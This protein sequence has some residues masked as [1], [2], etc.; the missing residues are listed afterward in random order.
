[1]VMGKVFTV[2][3][4][5]RIV[6]KLINGN[7]EFANLQVQ[8]EVSNFKKYPSGHCYFSLKDK[9]DTLKAVMFAGAAARLR[10]LPQNGNLILAL[11]RL[12]VFPRDG[13]YQLYVDMLMPLGAGNLM[14]AYEELKN[15]LQAEGLFEQ[16]RK[17]ALPEHPATVGIITSSAGAAVRDIITVSRRRDKGIKLLLYPVRVQGAEAAGELVYAIRFMNKHKLAEVLIVG[18]GGGSIE[19]LW[20]FNEEKVVRAI[21]ASELPIVSAVGHETD[22]TLADFAADVRAATPSAAAEIVVPDCNTMLVDVEKLGRRNIRAMEQF[23]SSWQNKLNGLERAWPFT[24]PERLFA[25]Q[26]V[27]LDKAAAG[28]QQV[29][30]TYLAKHDNALNVLESKLTALSPMAILARGYTVTETV[31]GL[32]V[33]SALQVKPGE[34]ILTRFQDGSVLSEIEPAGKA[35]K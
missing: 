9:N 4:V 20:A 13:V 6:K 10:Q 2:S 32:L 31:N 15:R 12:D 35:E 18:R 23:I 22:F 26:E 33:K 21:A 27:R 34:K 19:D 8:G 24:Q 16:A 11:G 7:Q 28:L 5:N 25:Q 14:L 29:M 3:E 30:K 17:K 1:M